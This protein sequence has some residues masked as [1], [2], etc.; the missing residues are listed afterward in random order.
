MAI[1][2]EVQDP[3]YTF[4]GHRIRKGQIVKLTAAQLKAGDKSDPP[5]F[6][7]VGAPDAN[8]AVVDISPSGGLSQATTAP[9]EAKSDK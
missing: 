3:T 1:Y 7:K 6:K 8:V 2:A 4:K 9:A 5:R